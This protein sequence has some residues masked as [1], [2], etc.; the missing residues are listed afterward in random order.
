MHRFDAYSSSIGQRAFGKHAVPPIGLGVHLSVTTPVPATEMISVVEAA[1]A[2]VVATAPTVLRRPLRRLA[3][4]SRPPTPEGS[5]PPFGWGNVATPIRSITGRPS[6]APSSSTRCP[7]GSPCGSPSPAGGHRVYHVALRKQR[8][9]GPASTPVARQLRRMSSEHP[10]LA[11]YLLVQANSTL[12]LS[13]VTTLGAVH[14][15]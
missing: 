11:T 13:Y 8:G 9:L 6:L 5:Q 15:G 4:R 10:G 3:D 2:T 1:P 12:G 14:L 7:I